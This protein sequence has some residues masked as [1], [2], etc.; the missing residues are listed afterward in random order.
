MS[1]KVYLGV[2]D[3]DKETAKFADAMST[4]FF[5]LLMAKGEEGKSLAAIALFSLLD[6]FT[7]SN[8]AIVDQSLS[9]LQVAVFPF[10]YRVLHVAAHYQPRLLL[11]MLSARPALIAWVSLVSSFPHV[12]CT[13]PPTEQL[14]AHYVRYADGS[15]HHS[16]VS[17]TVKSGGSI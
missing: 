11:P 17:K 6:R 12:A 9:L 13:L 14:I 8:V 10:A 4:Q 3:C 7:E 5:Q 16:V 15:E 1:C 2:K